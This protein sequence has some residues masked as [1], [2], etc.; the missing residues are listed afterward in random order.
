MKLNGSTSSWITI[1][2]GNPQGSALRPLLFL[3]YINEMPSLV[4]FG[5]L[6]QFADDTI[7]ICCDSDNNSVKIQLSHD[8]ALPSN[9]ISASHLT[10]NI[11]KSSVMWFTP[12][13]S[14]IVPCPSIVTNDN[15][16]KEVDHQ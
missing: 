15:L 12:K 11:D 13:C 4:K 6:L 5:K 14:Q 3:V 16:L 7:L 10:F 2:G 1:K 9:W 8:L